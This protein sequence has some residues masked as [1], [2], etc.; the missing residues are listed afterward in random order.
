VTALLDTEQI[1]Q[2][3]GLQR[4]YVTDRLTK[5]ADFPAPFINLTR[6]IRKWKACDVTD[7]MARHQ[8]KRAAMSAADSL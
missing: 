8:G 6:R 5:R 7:Y 4:A 1:A 3:Y 2:M